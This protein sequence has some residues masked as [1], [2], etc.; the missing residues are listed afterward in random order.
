VFGGNTYLAIVQSHRKG[1]KLNFP[2]GKLRYDF[3]CRLHKEFKLC[4]RSGYTTWPFKVHPEVYHPKYS[5]FLREGKINVNVNHF[6][7]F[8]HAY[9]RRTI[10]SI[11]SRRM[12]VTLYIP[13]MEK[14]FTN[15]K[16][17]AWF[18]NIEEG[19][20]IVRYYLDHDN[21][22]EEIAE[23]GYALACRSFTFQSRQSDFED[24]TMPMLG[25]KKP[26]KGTPPPKKKPPP[27]K[28]KGKK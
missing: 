8:R 28:K 2:G 24:Q 14:H 12:H 20:D 26:K 25:M 22:R 11:F 13:G 3:V 19:I 18:R 5:D 6:P 17:L 9:T 15:H 23:A 10:R 1:H 4:V 16:H 21:E 27:P 7:T